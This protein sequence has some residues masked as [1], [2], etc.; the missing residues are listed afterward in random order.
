M[1]STY[2]LQMSV[3]ITANVLFVQTHTEEERYQALT[4]QC[5]IKQNEVQCRVT[6]LC[7]ISH[8]F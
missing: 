1:Q 8:S 6:I 3:V 7:P 5:W 2:V 4:E